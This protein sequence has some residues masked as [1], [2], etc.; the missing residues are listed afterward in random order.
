MNLFIDTSNN[1]LILIL[2]KNNQIIDFLILNNQIRI[3]DICITELTKFLDKN[4]VKV[5]EI[6]NLYATKGPGSYTGVR[7]AISVI[8]TLKVI[9]NKFNI[10]LISSLAFQAGDKQAISILDAKGSKLYFGVYE[11][12]KNIIKDQ[13]IPLEY[14]QD[15]KKQFKNFEIIEDYKEVDFIQVYKKIKDKFE[16]IKNIEDI[17]PMYI[18][19][20]I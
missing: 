11:N 13:L 1:K 6:E 15:F 19:H 12:K 7:V 17:K 9:N 10:F 18:K 2:E 20:F 4:N 16:L 8:K 14:L 3:S 5:Q